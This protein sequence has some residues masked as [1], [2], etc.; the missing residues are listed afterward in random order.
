[1]RVETSSNSIVSTS[2]VAPSIPSS[3]PLI[4]I[5]TRGEKRRCCLLPVTH[6]GRVRRGGGSLLSGSGRKKQGA[7]LFFS[8]FCA[9]G[10]ESWGLMTESC[11]QG[12]V[13]LHTSYRGVGDTRAFLI[14]ETVERVKSETEVKLWIQCRWTPLHY[15]TPSGAILCAGFV[16]MW[17]RNNLQ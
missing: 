14:G 5:E 15:K 7:A 4:L 9:G 10:E 1:M 6:T 3:Q 8:P 11:L 12:R 17:H 2:P 16:R 13:G